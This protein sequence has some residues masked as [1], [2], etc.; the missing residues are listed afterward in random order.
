MDC[1]PQTYATLEDLELVLPA[2][3]YGSV[4]AQQRLKALQRASA[5]ADAFLRDRYA[6]PLRC[7]CGCSCGF[8][9]SLVDAVCE[10]ASYRIVCLRG[11]NPDLGGDQV[12]RQGWADAV[13]FLKR[14]ANGQAQ[15]KVC[16]SNPPSLQPEVG[17]NPARGYGS[18]D[19][20]PGTQDLP[21]VGGLGGGWGT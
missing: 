1:G 20:S 6:L 9:P 3:A 14:V 17:T 5:Y 8:D 18:F 7:S 15:L 12:I 10:L 4:T 2:K 21:V 13:D 19:L 11:Y 16:Q